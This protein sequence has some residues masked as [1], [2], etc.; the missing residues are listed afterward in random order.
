LLAGLAIDHG[1]AKV[2]DAAQERWRLIDAQLR[3]GHVD[4]ATEPWSTASTSPRDRFLMGGA[5][6]RLCRAGDGDPTTT[7]SCSTGPAGHS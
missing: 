1:V 4:P 3:A 7:S 2:C 5:A 6:W